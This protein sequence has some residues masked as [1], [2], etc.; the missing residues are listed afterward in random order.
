MIARILQRCATRTAKRDLVSTQIKLRKIYKH[1]CREG[2]EQI[3]G[4]LLCGWD[5]LDFKSA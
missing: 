2:Q 3:R 1:F 4:K 5:C